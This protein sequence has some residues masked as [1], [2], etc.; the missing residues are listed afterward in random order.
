KELRLLGYRDSGMA[1][2]P[3]NNHPD[4]FWRANFDEAVRSMV[5]HI[6]ELKPHVIVTY[7]AFGAYGHPDHI[8]AHRV[9]RAAFEAASDPRCYQDLELEAWQPAKLYYTAIRHEDIA[10]I[11]P[12]F[13]GTPDELITARIDI[14]PYFDTK[15]AAFR[16]HKTQ[17]APDEFFFSMSADLQERL[18]GYEHFILAV[19]KQ[20]KVSS[21]QENDLFY[22]LHS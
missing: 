8:Q 9:T 5:K 22:G 4:A 14:R 21:E 2:T 17:I 13:K 7:D 18:L 11:N 1:G 19:Q 10:E 16:V 6:R 20:G 12:E 3:A 15:L